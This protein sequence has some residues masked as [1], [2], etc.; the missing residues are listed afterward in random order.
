MP[1]GI[2]LDTGQLIIHRLYV[3]CNQVLLSVT[4]SEVLNNLSE[5]NATR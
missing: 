3:L 2:K 5:H 1:I 4:R